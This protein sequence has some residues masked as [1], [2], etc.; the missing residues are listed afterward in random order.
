MSKYHNR[1]VKTYDGNVHDSRKEAVRWMQLKL[2]ERAG[3]ITELKRQVK[4][5]L[6][7]SQYGTDE[8]GKKKLLEREASYIADFV[9]MENGKKVVE[10]V[11]GYKGGGAYS[12]F[13][14]KR[15]LMLQVYGIRIKEV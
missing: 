2:L 10:D 9:Y 5:V 13:S 14:I 3:Q 15:K 1:K 11:K 8:N 4:F 12:V 7:P 6:I